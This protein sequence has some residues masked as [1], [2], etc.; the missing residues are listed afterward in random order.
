MFS[1]TRI[2][3]MHRENIF[4]ALL[5]AFV[6]AFGLG[7]RKSEP[8]PPPPSVVAVSPDTVARVHWLGKRRLDLE[9]DAYYLSRVWS[10]PETARL[11]AQT[12]DRFSTG[13]WRFL[14]GEAAAA[15]IPP[16]MLRPLFDDLAQEEVYLEVRVPTNSQPAQACLAIHV[17]ARRAGIWETNL[18]IAAELLAGSLAVAEPARHGWTIQRTNAPNRIALTR[19]GEWTVVGVG[20]E[21]NP[22]FAEIT[23]RILRDSAPLPASPTN[24][25]LE[26]DFDLPRLAACFPTLNP[27]LSTNNSQPTTLNR[28]L[29]TVTGDGGNVIVHGQLTFGEPLPIQLEPWHIPL[30]LIHEPLIGFTAVRGIQP[31]LASWKTWSDLQIG[32]PPDQLYLWA[33]EG[34]SFQTYL[35]APLPD[36]GQKVSGLTDLLLQKGNPWLALR[37]YVSLDRASDSNGVTWGNLPTI[38][39]FIKSAGVGADG[40]LVAGL[41]PDT[42]VADRRPPPAG[43]IQDILGRTN[44]VYYDWEV[45][46]P[47]VAS[48]L[49]LGQTARQILRQ[50]QMSLDSASLNWLGVLVPRLGTS[51]TIVSLTAPNQLA[52]ARKSTL[53]FTALELHLLA[54]WLE[55]PQFP[56]GL[57]SMLAQPGNE[58]AR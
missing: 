45:T 6:I 1:G 50:A 47:R 5:T 58:G 46:G 35:A 9:A 28:F 3:A 54:D 31:W 30:D 26:A 2:R 49:E 8:P 34:S 41:L 10:L 20:P 24:F 38:R 23:A 44:L 40:W 7:C 39:P 18:A 48:G 17:P 27:Q 37:G 16:A 52:F 11:Q 25:W 43:M 22:L 51:A 13:A 33:L 21:K 42:G 36:A 12:F 29:L 32:A 56:R 15:Q 57:H 4:R 53:G 14:L 55:S 19:V